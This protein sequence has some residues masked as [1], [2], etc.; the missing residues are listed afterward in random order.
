MDK[1]GLLNREGLY[2]RRGLAL[3]S[4]ILG[5][6]LAGWHFYFF[7]QLLAALALFAMVVVPIL[8]VAFVL[9]LAEEAGERGIARIEE[10]IPRL[11]EDLKTLRARPRGRHVPEPL[12]FPAFAPRLAREFQRVN[13]NSFHLHH[14]HRAA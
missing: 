11:R 3:A 1:N 10:V 13:M 2:N 9:V 7:E 12:P 14:R 4:A 8:A 5:S 6:A